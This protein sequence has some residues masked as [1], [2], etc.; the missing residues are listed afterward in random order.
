MGE[1]KEMLKLYID[2]NGGEIPLEFS[3]FPGGEEHVRLLKSVEE[4]TT[5]TILANI[6]RS[7]ELMRLILLTDA[8][9][10]Q[11][12]NATLLLDLGYLP[13]ARQ[14]R[15]CNRGEALSLKVVCDIINNLDFLVVYLD[16]VHNPVVTLEYLERAHLFHIDEL[17]EP[18]QYKDVTK[19][20]VPDRGARCRGKL[21]SD[22]LEVPLIC[23]DKE[24][25]EDG[26]KITVEEG[27]TDSDVVLVVDD[28]CDAGG[29]FLALAKE[30]P[31][32]EKHLFVSN[33]IFSHD[34][35]V[36]LLTSYKTVAAYNDF[37]EQE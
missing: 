13:Y 28:I 16:D 2:N 18:D 6:D 1:N 22:L 4:Y 14:D 31:A 15:V 36:R 24:R 29:T 11:N 20:V 8:I 30:L 23:S 34:A 32:C 27:V 26:I 19:V 17:I 21:I 10:V 35:K 9:R 33:G 37:T 25:T 12:P 7:S 5:F 3:T